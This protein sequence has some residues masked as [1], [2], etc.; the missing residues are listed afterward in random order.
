MD[1]NNQDRD[2]ENAPFTR[3]IHCFIYQRASRVFIVQLLFDNPDRK[4][5]NNWIKN[6]QIATE[7][8]CLQGTL[9]LDID[10]GPVHACFTK[11]T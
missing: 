7:I 3:D 1:Y 9:F 8:E 6:I 5:P 4:Q 10:Q 2:R 11:P